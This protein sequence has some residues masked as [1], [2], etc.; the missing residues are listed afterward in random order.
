MATHRQQLLQQLLCDVAR[1]RCPLA[2]AVQVVGRK[3][4]VKVKAQNPSGVTGLLQTPLGAD[5][6]FNIVCCTALQAA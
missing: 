3:L 6:P 5:V 4:S 2:V 1:Q